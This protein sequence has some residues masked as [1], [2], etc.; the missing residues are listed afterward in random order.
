MNRIASALFAATV[1]LA[2]SIAP[3]AAEVVRLEI[4]GKTPYGTFRPGEY[5]LWRGK[6]HGELAPTEAI[7]DLDKA[8]R[9]E[10]GKVEYSS[11]VM[12]LMPADPSK[13]NG[14]LLVDIPNRGRVYGIALYNGPRGEPFNSGNIQ[15]G[16]GFL[17]DRGFSLAE[18]Q[19]ELGKGVEL[20]N[21]IGPDGKTRYVEGAGFAIVRDTADFLA[22]GAVDAAGTPNPLRGAIDRVLASGK[23]QSGRFLKTLLLAGFNKVNGHRV[24]DGMH[25]FVSGAGL[26]PILISS[27]GPQSSADSAP[28]FAD[29]EFRGVHEGPFTIGEIVAAVEKRGEVPPK[30][31]MVSSTTDF[32]SL[33]ASLG[34]TG[35]AGTEEQA[36][37]ANVRMYDVA[38][39]SHVVQSRSL[40]CTLPLARLDW[41]PVSRATLVALDRWVAANVAPPDSQLMPL[42]PATDADVLA[43]PKYL[44]KAVIERPKRDADGNVLGGVRLPDMAAPLGV[45]AAQQEPKSFGCSLAGAFLPFS[46]ARIAERYKNRDDYVNQIRTAARKLEAE[47]LLLPEDAAVI[48]NS[49]AALPWP[50]SATK[51]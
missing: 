7:P 44:P 29:P 3:V 25:I 10:A 42:E 51:K 16:T 12:L 40:E 14:T 45:H 41:T 1:L 6:V 36:I 48:V 17:E 33:R 34:R 47:R 50:P 38:G 2:V 11:E 18:V 46:E 19:W 23:S 24:I 15:Q 20:P 35:G 21:F 28:S 5:V 37:P 49:A 39:A 43:A 27:P 30:I 8:K 22:R 4:T 26:L 13:G 9:N 31:I 32:L